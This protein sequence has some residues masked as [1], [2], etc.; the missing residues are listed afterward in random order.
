MDLMVTLRSEGHALL[1]ISHN[2][3]SVFELADRIIVLRHG[4]KIAD[5]GAAETSR[6]NIISLLTSGRL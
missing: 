4:R 5:V 2:L 1:L 3:E 6:H